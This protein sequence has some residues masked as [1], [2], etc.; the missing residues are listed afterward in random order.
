MKSTRVMLIAALVV[1]AALTMPVMARIGYDTIV[2][3]DTVFIYEQVNLCGLGFTQN[4]QLFALG[5]NDEVKDTFSFTNCSDVR[6]PSTVIQNQPYYNGTTIS[7]SA[8]VVFKKPTLNID[9]MASNK[10]DVLNEKTVTKGTPVYFRVSSNVPSGFNVTTSPPYVEIRFTN[11]DGGSV[12]VFGNVSTFATQ[13]L[14]GEEEFIGLVDTSNVKSGTWKVQALWKSTAPFNDLYNRGVDSSAVFFTIGAAKPKITVSK[15]EVVRGTSFTA[16]ITGRGSTAYWLFVKDA[17]IECSEYVMIDPFGSGAQPGVTPIYAGDNANMA[18]MS[19]SGDTP[20]DCNGTMA[21]VT[22]N[23]AGTRTIS[24][25]TNENTKDR[26]FTLV[27]AEVGDEPNDDSV[28]IKVVKGKISIDVEGDK[29]YY[30]GEEIKFIGENT[31]SDYTYLFIVGPNLGDGKSLDDLTA[32]GSTEVEVE[33]DN[34]FEYKWDTGKYTL[35]AGTYTIYAVTKNVTGKDRLNSSMLWATMSIQLRKPFLTAEMATTRLAKGDKLVITGKAEGKPGSVYIWVFGPNIMG[36]LLDQLMDVSQSV[37]DDMSFKWEYENTG[38]LSSGQYFVVVQ[39]PM[40]NG[41]QDVER[42]GNEVFNKV[43]NRT[44]FYVGGDRTRLMGSDAAEA[45]V[46]VLNQPNI[47]DTYVKLYFM[48]EEGYINIDAIGDQYIGDKFTMKGTTNLAVDDTLI[49][50]VTSASFRP[51]EKTQ[52]S[53]FS[54][55]S[56]TVK[57]VKGTSVEN[58]WSFDVDTTG[59]KPD[60]YIVTVECVETGTTATTTFTVSE[61]PPATPTTPPTTPPV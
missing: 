51:T 7:G 16:T 27:V 6:I 28:N 29:V 12:N 19:K 26:T 30:V 13:N 38:S 4:G 52:A 37:E 57:V 18:N 11:P 49:I 50:T 10:L 41:E 5:A 54:G 56:G 3:G 21:R 39:H 44:E 33:D 43:F 42:R 32:P 9:V 40:Y 24:F 22:T 60:Q 31:E 53:E 48:L 46:Q 8:Y 1:L 17:S 47:D 20:A 23:A 61:V 14:T 25:N 15:D 55:A 58:A 2:S 36:S 34:T 35:D 59:F 45:L